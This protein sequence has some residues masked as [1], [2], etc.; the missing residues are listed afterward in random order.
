MIRAAKKIIIDEA[1]WRMGRLLKLRLPWLL[2]GLVVGMGGSVLMAQ[3]EKLLSQ[4]ISLA[5]FVPI[6]VYM[7]DAVGTQTETIFVR[8]LSG[9]KVYFFKYLSKE[10]VLG[11]YMG[12][13]LGAGIGI[14]AWLWLGQFKVALTVGLAMAIN[15][16]VA[17]MVALVVAEVL[18][19]RRADP[20]LGA[21]PLTTVVQDIFSLMV[22]LLTASIVM[23]GIMW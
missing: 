14:L 21:G 6:I 16:T 15:V 12:L 17:P 18:F 13:V 22:Y 19:K 1:H 3:F 9:K 2:V 20:A 5:F 8:D 23:W 11:G 10:L 7:S 4:N